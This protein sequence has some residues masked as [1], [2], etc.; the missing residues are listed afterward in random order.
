MQNKGSLDRFMMVLDV[1]PVV[2]ELFLPNFSQP[3]A[4]VSHHSELHLCLS[5]STNAKH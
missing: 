3:V 2:C 5:R 4:A 1:Q